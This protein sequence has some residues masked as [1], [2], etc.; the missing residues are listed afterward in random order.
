[1]NRM[2]NA[3]CTVRGYASIRFV[4]TGIL[5]YYVRALRFSYMKY[6]MSPVIH[7]QRS[8]VFRNLPLYSYHY[9]SPIIFIYFDGLSLQCVHYS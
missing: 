7:K 8:I 1:M 9:L 4:R 3:T 2:G 6:H 5:L